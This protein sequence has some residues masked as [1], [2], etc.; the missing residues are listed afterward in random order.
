MDAERI[1]ELQLDVARTLLDLRANKGV[2]SLELEVSTVGGSSVGRLSAPPD[3]RPV[4]SADIPAAIFKTMANL[5]RAL[6]QPGKGAWL[7]ANV[8]VDVSGKYSFDYNYDKRPHWNSRTSLLEPR[9]D[10]PVRPSDIAFVEDLEQFPRSPEN[11]PDWYPV[12]EVAAPEQPNQEFVEGSLF[13]EDLAVLETDESWAAI[14]RDVQHRAQSARGD[15]EQHSTIFNGVFDTFLQPADGAYVK[16]LWSAAAEVLELTGS[17]SPPA[18]S[19]S[20]SDPSPELERLLEDVSDV[21]TELIT[22]QL[23]AA[24]EN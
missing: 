5:R 19:E 8:A 3:E 4:S 23:D 24:A 9:P 11:I 1:H 21:I 16:R 14:A 7:S 15:S 12:A 20:V 2:T 22:V 6:Y 18:D 17:D 13:P 10:R